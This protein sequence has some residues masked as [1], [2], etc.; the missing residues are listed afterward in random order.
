MLRFLAYLGIAIFAVLPALWFRIG[1]HVL[2][3]LPGAAV[4]GIAI[5]SA[6]FMLSWGAEAAEERVS[7]GFMIARLALV[8]VLP[9]Y[10]V[11]IYLAIRAGEMPVSDYVHYAAANMT[12]AN[13][14]L[15]GLGWSL[16]VILHCI[17]SRTCRCGNQTR[18]NCSFWEQRLLTAL[19]SCGRTRSACSI[20]SS[21]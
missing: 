3:P 7:Q 14:L 15:V 18:L 20:L 13:R 12:G 2:S 17:K 8:T 5:L 4:F 6:G 19:S 11:D 10:A 21:C 1:E 9:E 16:V